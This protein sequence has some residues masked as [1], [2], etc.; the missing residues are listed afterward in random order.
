MIIEGTHTCEHCSEEF[1]WEIQMRQKLSSVRIL[2]VDVLRDDYVHPISV[3]NRDNT[4]VELRC[5]CPKCDKLLSFDSN[6]SHNN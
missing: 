6:V 4:Y 2:D 3:F 5:R 1:N